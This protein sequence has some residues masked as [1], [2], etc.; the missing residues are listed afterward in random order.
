MVNGLYD[1]WHFEFESIESV[2]L[3]NTNYMY[4]THPLSLLTYTQRNTDTD[5]HTHKA[6]K[7]SIETILI[8]QM[9]FILL[10]MEI[11]SNGF[12]IF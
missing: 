7:Y 9:D 11:Q 2:A 8:L 1:L 10:W 12:I 5:T 6:I 3:P 4:S